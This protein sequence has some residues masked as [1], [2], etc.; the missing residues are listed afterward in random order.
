VMRGYQRGAE[1]TE[2]S[3]S[4]LVELGGLRRGV[5]QRGLEATC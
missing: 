1:A 4:E 5:W 3:D 2:E